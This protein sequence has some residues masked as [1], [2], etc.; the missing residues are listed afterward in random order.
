MEVEDLR[1]LYVDQLRDL[2]SAENQL[3]KALPKMAKA[4]NDEQLKQGFL[5]HLEETKGH[6]ERLTTI[7]ERLNEKPGGKKCKAMEGLI[8]EGKEMIE[9]DAS[10]EA[11]DAGLIAAAQRVEHYEIAGYGTV[12]AYAKLLGEDAAI[13]LLQQTLD[14]EAAADRKL[15]A[16]AENT[17]NLQAVGHSS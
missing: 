4:A 7:F 17:I 6:V 1:D 3:V 5:D 2:Y 13:K 11:K 16:L 14:E 12:R 15:T 9:E 8:E 10:P